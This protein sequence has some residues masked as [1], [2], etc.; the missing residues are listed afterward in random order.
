MAPIEGPSAVIDLIASLRSGVLVT[1]KSDGRPQ[2]SNV[3]YLFD[4]GSGTARVSI[5]AERAKYKNLR[6]DPRASLYATTA[7]RWA[8][9]VAEGDVT[10]SPVA[11]SVDDAAVTELV[12][13]Y[14]DIQGEH[15]DW[16]EYRRAMVDDRRVVVRLH[17]SKVYGLAPRG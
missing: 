12:E 3:A 10:L 6:R 8:Y 7:D 13:L 15:P 5:T 9:G 17:V 16:D 2:L 14:R 4:P 1:V 11:E